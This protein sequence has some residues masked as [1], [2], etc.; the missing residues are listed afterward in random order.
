MTYILIH[1]NYSTMIY[2]LLYK[3]FSITNLFIEKEF[4]TYSHFNIKSDESISY[5]VFKLEMTKKN[6]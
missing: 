6:N 1:K 2:D 3:Y 5:Y 4:I